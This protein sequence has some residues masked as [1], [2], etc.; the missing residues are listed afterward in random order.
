MARSAAL[1]FDIES[2]VSNFSRAMQVVENTAKQ[3]AAGFVLEFTGAGRKV[4]DALGSV[5][6]RSAV[7]IGDALSGAA[8]RFEGEFAKAAANVN[9]N[10]SKSLAS[11]IKP[12]SF[13]AAGLV[14]GV[15]AIVV[16]AATA[17]T[18]I[19]QANAQLD[20]FISLGD[21]AAA[22]GV[23]VDF[24]QRFSEAATKA[25]IDV[26]EVEAALKKAGEAVTPKFEQE[27]P[28][29]KQ[30]NNLF[31]TGYLGDY[32]SKGLQDYN[33]ADSN[34]GRIR[35]AVTAMQEL[36]SLGE[37]LAAIDLASKLF[38]PE[39]AERIRS[40]KLDISEIAA[41]LD[42]KRDDVITQAQV[43]QAR[44]FREQLDEAYKAIDDAL[45][46]SVALEGA[47]QDLL[48]VWLGIAQGIAAA[49]KEVGVL[50]DK[51]GEAKQA[52]QDMMGQLATAL[53]ANAINRYF[54]PNQGRTV[55]TAEDPQTVSAPIAAPTPPRRPLSFYTD[56]RAERPARGGG[57]KSPA[58]ESLD[59]VETF[60]N[61]IERSTV[62]LKAE[63]DAIGKSAAER[64]SLINV[65]R[66]EAVARQ[67]GITLTDEQIAK[68][69]ALSASTAEYREKIEDAQEAQ[70]AMRSIGGDFLKGIAHDAQ[71]GASALDIL[72]GA[73]SRLAQKLGDKALD[74][75]ADSLFGKSGGQSGSGL[76]GGLFGSGGTNGGGSILSFF[77][78][79]FNP[80]PS[81]DVGGFT[82]AGP[83]LQPAGIVHRG[84]VVFSQR[85]V[86]RHGGP[87]VVNRIRL[88]G[89]GYADG[90]VVA[91]EFSDALNA[92]VARMEARPAARERTA[93]EG[94][95]Q[96]T[97]NRPAPAPTSQIIEGDKVTVQVLQP[98]ASAEQIGAVV[99]RSNAQRDRTLGQRLQEHRQRFG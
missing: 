94:L 19:S 1:S 28:V 21:N 36:Q 82:G 29:K 10:L 76:L 69:K 32:Q 33:A 25:K 53:G 42:R 26:A 84:E 64:Q 9:A 72:T 23:G 66:L 61:G 85:D 67:Q 92:S 3:K 14:A 63:V 49:A 98:G 4:D 90:G 62:A 22:A 86:A 70:A 68:T 58:T 48:N 12:V 7:Q 35:A 81:F 80:I 38:G 91:G 34:E 16:A 96:A 97:A 54:N 40:G 79:G 18:A 99:Q 8:K 57:S 17:A 93:M 37:R 95:S 31:E 11:A 87:A 20:R 51:L 75:L 59:Q 55:A 30:L 52:S 46:V 39:L 56:E 27:D 74:S 2:N 43:E 24:F 15:A 45:H 78:G 41:S 65:A 73:V 5:G 13:G 88:G 89:P 50:I 71:S 77:T 44:Q 47:G 83:R 60:I 6:K